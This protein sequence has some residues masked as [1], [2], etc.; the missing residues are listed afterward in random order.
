MLS[1]ACR[2]AGLTPSD[3]DYVEAHGT[4]TPVGDPIEANA[5][6]R[7]FGV[8]RNRRRP[9]IVGAGK[10]NTGHLES[11]A[12]ITGL[13]KTALCL[14]RREI[15]RNINFKRANPNIPFDDLGLSLPLEHK[16]WEADS[17]RPRRAR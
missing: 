6:G 15:P 4:G 9:V 14:D 16:K 12:G 5:I 7:V 2:R 1:E 10:T 17:D 3:I 13:I 8:E 11:A